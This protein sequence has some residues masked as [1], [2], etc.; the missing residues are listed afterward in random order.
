MSASAEVALLIWIDINILFVVW[1]IC[2]AVAK[3]DIQVEAV[4]SRS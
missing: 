4:E 3:G 1:R 2:R